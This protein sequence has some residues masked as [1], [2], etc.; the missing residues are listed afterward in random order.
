MRIL[1]SVAGAGLLRSVFFGAI[2][3]AF[4]CYKT[5]WYGRTLLLQDNICDIFLVFFKCTVYVLFL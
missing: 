4:F 2:T 1:H 5:N 3:T